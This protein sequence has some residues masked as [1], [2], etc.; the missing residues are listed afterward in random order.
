MDNQQFSTVFHEIASMLE[1]QKDDPFRIRAY[2]R[3]AQTFAHLNESLWSIAKRDALEEIPGVGKTLARE[4]RELL[5]T[6]QL[7]YHEH[8]KS[9][10]PEGILP[11]LHLTSLSPE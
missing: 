9:T 6:G 8:L 4:I 2:R 3:A 5:E 11:L 7:R 10:V 1:L